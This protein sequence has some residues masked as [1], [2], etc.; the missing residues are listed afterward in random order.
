MVKE[1]RWYD[2]WQWICSPW[3]LTVSSLKLVLAF[4]SKLYY[5]PNNSL[6]EIYLKA[7]RWSVSCSFTVHC[8]Y[9]YISIVPVLLY[10]DILWLSLIYVVSTRK[11]KTIR[12]TNILFAFT[13]SDKPCS[14]NCI[15]IKVTDINAIQRMVRKLSDVGYTAMYVLKRKTKRNKQTNK[16]RRNHRLKTET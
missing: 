16:Q 9:V 12:Y 14:L 2:I 3:T 8:V 1:L 11:Y 13:Y 15:D 4:P 7:T 5:S 10:T 6:I